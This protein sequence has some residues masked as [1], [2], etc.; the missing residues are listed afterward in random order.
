MT[1]LSRSGSGALSASVEPAVLD[2]EDP[3][4][5]VDGVENRLLVETQ[6]GEELSFRG[7]GAGPEIAGLGVLNDLKAVAGA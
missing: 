3:L 6:D 1:T 2:D 5:E 7:P 4:R